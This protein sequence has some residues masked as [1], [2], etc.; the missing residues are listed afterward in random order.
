MFLVLSFFSVVLSC[1]EVGAR[2]GNIVFDFR[3]VNVVVMIV[4]GGRCERLSG[5]LRLLMRFVKVIKH[6]I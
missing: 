4:G 1:Q 3:V 6:G 2:K 5:L